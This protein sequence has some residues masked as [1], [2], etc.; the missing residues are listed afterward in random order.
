MMRYIEDMGALGIL[1][2][3]TKL[4]QSIGNINIPLKLYLNRNLRPEKNS[5]H[6]FIEINDKFAITKAA[7]S[8][9]I[10]GE[11]HIRIEGSASFDKSLEQPVQ[12]QPQPASLNPQPTQIDYMKI[13]EEMKEKLSQV[14]KRVRSSKQIMG[15]G[16]K[17]TKQTQAER[18][19]EEDDNESVATDQEVNEIIER[20]EKLKTKM[21]KAANYKPTFDATEKVWSL[22]HGDIEEK[23]VIPA[24]ALDF[25]V[26]SVTDSLSDITIYQKADIPIPYK[27]NICTDNVTD[28][29][30]KDL[31][32]LSFTLVAISVK[33]KEM[34]RRLLGRAYV[35]VTLPV[36]ERGSIK[37]REE[38]LKAFFSLDKAKDVIE[39]NRTHEYGI[40]INDDNFG[41]LVNSKIDIKLMSEL[42]NDNIFQNIG[43]GEISLQKV[44]LAGN[45]KL[46][47]IVQLHVMSDKSID[48]K[49]RNKAKVSPEIINLRVI[50]ELTKRISDEK[51]R[52]IP[53]Q[54]VVNKNQSI[55]KGIALGLLLFIKIRNAQNIETNKYGTL[56]NLYIKYK[57]FLTGE[58]ISTP[59]SW[60]NTSFN[61]QIQYPIFL[62]SDII[63]RISNGLLVF[64]VWDKHDHKG[65]QQ[66]DE[67]IGLSKVM[68][69]SFSESLKSQVVPGTFTVHHI[70]VNQYPFIVKDDYVD[71]ISPRLGRAVGSLGLTVAIGTPAQV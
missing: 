28:E 1:I 43:K 2:Y 59:V 26:N 11:V 56:P 35:L 55:V 50:I 15:M 71:I 53:I 45:H 7:N 60:G 25:E 34:Q 62:S 33:S 48:K 4:K 30:L 69:K 14:K 29:Q 40:N 31:N 39:L 47:T 46:D 18:C 6:I 49:N 20:G 37:P 52:L 27:E 19:F 36:F 3:D 42:N 51:G 5:V 23:Q 57:N 41:N 16:P 68:L 65:K 21:M 61:H 70:L 32:R 10:I 8:K 58:S 54:A 24:D 66:T 13:K 63:N 12:V 64:E 9:Q 17:Q 22:L 44:V 38:E 67:L